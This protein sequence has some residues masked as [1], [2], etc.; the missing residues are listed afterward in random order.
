MENGDG[1][2]GYAGYTANRPPVPCNATAAQ[3][4]PPSHSPLPA[5]VALSRDRSAPAVPAPR[6]AAGA[7]R[8]R[9]SQPRPSAQPGRKPR[10]PRPPANPRPARPRAPPTPRPARAALAPPP[11]SPRRHWLPQ[12]S[13]SAGSSSRP[14]ALPGP[15]LA[16]AARRVCGSSVGPGRVSAASSQRGHRTGRHCLAAPLASHGP[17]RVPAGRRPCARWGAAVPR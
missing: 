3:H 7:A 11:S 1:C 8:S 12:P 16:A 5:Q 14:P 15:L 4:P 9:S 6:T 13:I 2:G 10:Q 17:G